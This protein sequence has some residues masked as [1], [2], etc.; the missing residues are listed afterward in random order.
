MVCIFFHTSFQS[1]FLKHLFF[2]KSYGLQFLAF[3][4]VSTRRSSAMKELTLVLF[5]KQLNELVVVSVEE[6]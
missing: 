1:Y 5:S 3:S 4:T 2:S 6:Q